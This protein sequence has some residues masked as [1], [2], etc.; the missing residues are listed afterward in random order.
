MLNITS[1]RI[2]VCSDEKIRWIVFLFCTHSMCLSQVILQQM[3]KLKREMCSLCTSFKCHSLQLP[4]RLYQALWQKELICTLIPSSLSPTLFR[5]FFLLIGSGERKDFSRRWVLST[6]QVKIP[7]NGKSPTRLIF[8]QSCLDVWQEWYVKRGSVAVWFFSEGYLFPS[9]E[10]LLKAISHLL[11]FVYTR[12]Y[13]Q[14]INKYTGSRVLNYWC[15][16]WHV[17]PGMGVLLHFLPQ[18]HLALFVTTEFTTKRNKRLWGRETFEK[19]LVQRVFGLLHVPRA[20]VYSIELKRKK[21]CAL[22]TCA[23]LGIH[24]SIMLVKDSNLL[25]YFH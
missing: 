6:T 12:K 21:K 1:Y 24:F 23:A 20:F 22:K 19:T 17:K 3:W 25:T 10:S 16:R 4:P 7:K 5:T 11:S 8:L 2:K 14:T 15:A 9:Q 18:R 13:S